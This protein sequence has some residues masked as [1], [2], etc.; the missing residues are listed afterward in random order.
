MLHEK[1]NVI[2]NY[3]LVNIAAWLQ[4]VKAFV[5]SFS[6]RQS[7]LDLCIKLWLRPFEVQLEDK[8]RLFSQDKTQQ[9]YFQQYRKIYLQDDISK[10]N[11]ETQHSL[12][13][14][15]NSTESKFLL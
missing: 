8:D 14:I 12:F 15:Y 9:Y 13:S 10:Q 6:V 4:N 3:F 11:C 5:I 1:R 2:I 7:F